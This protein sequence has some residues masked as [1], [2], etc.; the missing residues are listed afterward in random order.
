MKYANTS[1][2][3]V[4]AIQYSSYIFTNHFINI[5]KSTRQGY[6]LYSNGY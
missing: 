3:E 2:E 4:Y 5:H 1:H 6:Q